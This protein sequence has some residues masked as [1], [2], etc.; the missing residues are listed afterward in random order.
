VARVSGEAARLLDSEVAKGKVDAATRA[1]LDFGIGRAFMLAGNGPC[2]AQRF[3]WVAKSAEAPEQLK[4]LAQDMLADRP[5]DSQGGGRCFEYELYRPTTMKAQAARYLSE[6]PPKKVGNQIVER[7]YHPPERY[8]SRVRFTGRLRP[9]SPERETWVNGLYGPWELTR[10]I[11]SQPGG[12]ALREIEVEE[13]GSLR[14][15][16][17]QDGLVEALK[18]ERGGGGMI[19][20]FVMFLGD[21]DGDPTFI[22]GGFRAIK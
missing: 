16:P 14:W 8:Q 1:S 12:K 20:L 13:A 21:L 9:L 6:H 17:I 22:A 19:D 3:R 10:Q 15:V 7:N 11:P 18:A 5:S 2:A 4:R